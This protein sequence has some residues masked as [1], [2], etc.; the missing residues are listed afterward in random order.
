[1]GG[2]SRSERNV[3]PDHET[4]PYIDRGCDLGFG[5][6]VILSPV[7]ATSPIAKPP[8]WQGTTG[9]RN[10]ALM[11]DTDPGPKSTGVAQTPW[12]E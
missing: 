3:Q 11:R 9:A 1:M 6:Q 4:R 12:Q 8:P 2:L 10:V 5:G 7:L